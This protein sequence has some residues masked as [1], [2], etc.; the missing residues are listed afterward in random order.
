VCACC[1]ASTELRLTLSALRYL[2]T[3]YDSEGLCKQLVQTMGLISDCDVL[4]EVV[5]AVP[6]II[7]STAQQ[8]RAVTGALQAAVVTTAPAV[9]C[10]SAHLRFLF[11]APVLRSLF[12]GHR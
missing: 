8:V 6:E 4:R 1:S 5:M 11:A 9:A 12:P 3:V 7:G 2:D 10:S